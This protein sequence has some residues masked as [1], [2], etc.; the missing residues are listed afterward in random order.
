MLH[1]TFFSKILSMCWGSG[2][3]H[4][5]QVKTRRLYRSTGYTMCGVEPVNGNTRANSAN[6]SNRKIVMYASFK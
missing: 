2:N 5:A 6:A 1:T 3:K 4:S